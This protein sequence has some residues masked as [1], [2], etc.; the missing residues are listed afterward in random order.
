MCRPP[1]STRAP[2]GR[3]PGQPRLEVGVTEALSVRGRLASKF[4]PHV[5]H[6]R[7]ITHPGDV[8]LPH[9][10]R[11]WCFRPVARSAARFCYTEPRS[12]LCESIEFCYASILRVPWQLWLLPTDCTCIHYCTHEHGFIWLRRCLTRNVIIW[13]TFMLAFHCT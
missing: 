2:R 6:M 8:P 1:R 11:H 5:E 12:V 4:P 3:Q 9:E 13:L 10:Q 7:V